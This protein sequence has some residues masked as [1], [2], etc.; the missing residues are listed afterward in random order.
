[1]KPPIPFLSEAVAF[2]ALV[3][4]ALRKADQR[5]QRRLRRQPKRRA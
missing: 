4:L 3:R 5:T 2:I 1:M